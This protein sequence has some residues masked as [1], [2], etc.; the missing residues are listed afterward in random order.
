MCHL[1]LEVSFKNYFWLSMARVYF[2][3]WGKVALQCCVSFCCATSKEPEPVQS[4]ASISEVE[5]CLPSP[6]ADD[7]S[8]DDPST[9][10]ISSPSS[11]GN[12]SCLFTQCQPLYAHLFTVLLCF[13][14]FFKVKNVYDL[15]FLCIFCEKYYKPITAQ[16]SIANCI[17]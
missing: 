4:M 7:P 16:Y 5:A 3:N 12:S 2:F 15:C 9:T 8:A 1:Q 10:P 6:I 13:S 17:S 14:R 11:I